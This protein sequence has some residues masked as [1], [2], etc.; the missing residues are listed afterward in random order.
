MNE[1]D[2]FQRRGSEPHSVSRSLSYVEI[3]RIHFWKKYG[4][5][6]KWGRFTPLKRYR[7]ITISVRQYFY[8]R[9]YKFQYKS[10]KML[11]ILK[12]VSNLSAYFSC[13]VF[14]ILTF[15]K[16]LWIQ[17]SLQIFW[18]KVMLV[19]RWGK[20]SAILTTGSFLPL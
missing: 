6:I 2:F 3:F 16:W 1:E 20:G 12:K 7:L 4:E 10:V 9:I 14:Y 15:K 13:G 18:K 5:S 17:A 19:S 11:L 8:S